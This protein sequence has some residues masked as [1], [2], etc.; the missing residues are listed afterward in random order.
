MEKGNPEEAL[1]SLV[2]IQHFNGEIRV[3]TLYIKSFQK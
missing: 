1:E 2:K 3:Y